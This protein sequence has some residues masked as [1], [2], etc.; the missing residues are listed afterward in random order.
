MDEIPGFRTLVEKQMQFVER[1]NE[2]VMCLVL[3]ENISTLIVAECSISPNH[4]IFGV[5]MC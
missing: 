3:L 2:S 4:R 5:Y 1:T